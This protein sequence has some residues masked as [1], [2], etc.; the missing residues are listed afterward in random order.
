[1]S[2]TP[3]N[4]IVLTGT[5]E[6]AED[7]SI[8]DDILLA[9]G[10]TLDWAD[11]SA[12]L[13]Y[14]ALD[15]VL[16]SDSPIR[17]NTAPSNDDDLT[18]KAYVD[19][20]ATGLDVKAS[21][22]VASQEDVDLSAPGASIDGVTLANG[23]RVLIKAQ[24]AAE[25]NG[26]YVFDTDATPMTRAM[27]ADSNDE[28]TAGMFTFVEQGTNADQGW[29]LTTDNPIDLGADELSFSQFSNAVIVSTLDS[30]T[31]VDVAGAATGSA[32]I[33]DGSDWVDS[34][35]FIVDD[36]NSKIELGGDTNL[37][38]EDDDILATDDSLHVVGKITGDDGAE[39]TVG[40]MA[41]SS[42]E[43]QIVLGTSGDVNLYRGDDNQLKTDDNLR[44]DGGSILADNAGTLYL[45][46]E[47]GVSS[48]LGQFGAAG[49]TFTDEDD[50]TSGMNMVAKDLVL[51]SSAGDVKVDDDLRVTG[52]AYIGAGERKLTDNG[53]ELES[54]GSMAINGDL[55]VD[56]D[57]RMEVWLDRGNDSTVTSISPSALGFTDADADTASIEMSNKDLLLTGNGLGV[58]KLDGPMEAAQGVRFSAINSVDANIALDD[59]TDHI[60]LVDS[61]DDVVTVTLPAAPA[62]G[63]I[64]QIKDAGGMAETNPI[65][66]DGNGNNIDGA[67]SFEMGVDYQSAS[68]IFDG[69]AWFLI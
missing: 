58:I 5:P 9:A 54:D 2:Y 48:E 34:V 40:N 44:V 4:N 7:I 66:I 3:L 46:T 52:D 11:G 6:V 69:A 31:D 32:L 50:D 67:A 28:V 65:T 16:V 17:V 59:R 62:A 53:A 13:E 42:D 18:N 36:A 26:I 39:I 22:R 55:F 25:D 38:R 27:D 20:V 68:V 45:Y 29:V 8:G 30:L 33:F 23:D 19:S 49:M 1:M 35:N 47:E 64:Y 24:D 37:Y 14:N 41:L 15:D 63:T 12:V 60:V 61:T 57:N 43:G 56:S 51:G 10:S 21:V